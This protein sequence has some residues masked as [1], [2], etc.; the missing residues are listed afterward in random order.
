VTRRWSARSC[1]ALR[2]SPPSGAI[3]ERGYRTVF[4]C[5]ARRADGVPR[6]PASAAG[7]R[8]VAARVEG[9]RTKTRDEGRSR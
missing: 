2:P 3:A 8:L 4:N 1:G 6:P 7:E 5:N 9:R